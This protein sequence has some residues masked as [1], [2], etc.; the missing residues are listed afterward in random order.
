MSDRS[1]LGPDLHLIQSAIDRSRQ[2]VEQ[3]QYVAVHQPTPQWPAVVAT[4]LRRAEL[5]VGAARQTVAAETG[6]PL[7]PDEA[8][9]RQLAASLH[10]LGDAIRGRR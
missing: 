3:A 5:S 7:P 8:A 6:L 1:T 4:L 10:D 2:L 9:S